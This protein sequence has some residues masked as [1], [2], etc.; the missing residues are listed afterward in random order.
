VAKYLGETNLIKEGFILAHGFIPISA[1][2]ID[3][4]QRRGRVSW[5]RECVAVCGRKR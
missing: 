4:G 5:W 1:S 2:S 3:L